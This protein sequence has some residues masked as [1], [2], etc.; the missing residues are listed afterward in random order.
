VALGRVLG[1]R[2]MVLGIVST[3]SAQETEGLPKG[4]QLAAARWFS[5]RGS[6][7]LGSSGWIKGKVRVIGCWF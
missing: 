7:V 1:V 4:S 5:G 6:T 3:N 2:G